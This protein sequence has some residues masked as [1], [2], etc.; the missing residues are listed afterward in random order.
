[1]RCA[2][3][4]LDCAEQDALPSVGGHRAIRQGLE[5]RQ[6]G[7]SALCPTVGWGNSPSVLRD[8]LTPSVFLVPRPLDSD[9]H[10]RHPILDLMLAGEG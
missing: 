7:E 9:W 3:K 4:S 10:L 6:K 2:F 8:S 5:D 1:M